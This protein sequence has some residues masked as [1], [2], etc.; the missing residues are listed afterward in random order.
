MDEAWHYYTLEYFTAVKINVAKGISMKML[1]LKNS[2][3]KASC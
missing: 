3:K 2:E 1:N